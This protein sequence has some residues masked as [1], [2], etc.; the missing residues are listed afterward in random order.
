MDKVLSFTYLI[1]FNYFNILVRWEDVMII[2]TFLWVAFDSQFL[3]FSGTSIFLHGK[4]AT[5]QWLWEKVDT[6]EKVYDPLVYD[7]WV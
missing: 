7:I 6:V 4:R 5:Q 3:T 2:L 1:T